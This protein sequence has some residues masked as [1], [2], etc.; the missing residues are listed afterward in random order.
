MQALCSFFLSKCLFRDLW[1]QVLCTGEGPASAVLPLYRLTCNMHMCVYCVCMTEWERESE[2]ELVSERWKWSH[3]PQSRFI[4]R[5]RRVSGPLRLGMYTQVRPSSAGAWHAY[6][7]SN[8]S[9]PPVTSLSASFHPLLLSTITFLHLTLILGQC[10]NTEFAWK[11]H[12]TE[13]HAHTLH[14]TPCI[15]TVRG[16]TVTSAEVSQETAGH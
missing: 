4:C 7:H 8:H 15:R 9:F 5:L 14:T 13:T 6:T 10:S 16:Q 2:C 1:A 3:S 12:H 11:C